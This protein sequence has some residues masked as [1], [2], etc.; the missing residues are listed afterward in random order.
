MVDPF[1]PTAGPNPLDPVEDAGGLPV[2]PVANPAVAQRTAQ[3]AALASLGASDQAAGIFAAMDEKTAS[4]RAQIDAMGDSEV[5]A[6]AAARMQSQK[7]DALGTVLRDALPSGDQELVRGSVAAYANL[8][9][10]DAQED[11]SY[12]L[13]QQAIERVQDLAAGGN[14]VQARV[15]L[16]N[17]ENGNALD[18]MRDFTAKQ[19]VMQNMIDKAEIAVKDQGWFRSLADMAMAVIPLNA[20][21][22]T[23]NV[24]VA[25]VTKRWYDSLLAGERFQS[26]ADSLW[27]L[28]LAEFSKYINEDFMRNLNENTT[29]FGYHNN[30][31]ELELLTGLG[32]RTPSV[33]ETNAWNTLDI[34]GFVP[35]TK[36]AG[37]GRAV[38]GFGGHMVANG[39]R[40]EAAEMFAAEALNVVRG[41]TQAVSGDGVAMAQIREALSVSAVTPNNQEVKVALGVSTGSAY[42]RG[43]A[44]LAALPELEARARLDGAELAKALDVTRLRLERAF[45]RE[46]KDVDIEDVELAGGSRTHRVSVTMGRKDGDGFATETQ[47]N[48]YLSSIG[49]T[50]EAIQDTSGQWFAKV[51]TDLSETGFTTRL[52]NVKSPSPA[53][54]LLNAR[55]VGD[56][57]LAN[58]AAVAG[59]ARNKLLRTLVEPYQDTFRS[60]AKHEKDSLAQVL[61]A[62]E[63]NATW[64]TK[65]QIDTLYQR[66]FKRSPS[67]KELKAYQAARDINDMEYS[68][69]NDE[70]YKQKVI[71]GF[72]SVSFDTGRGRVDAA[73]AIVDRELKEAPRQRVFDVTDG[74]HYE[75]GIPPKTW[76]KM[77]DQGYTIIRLEK[78]MTLAD[79]T[80]IKTFAVRGKDVAIE[81]LSREQ[82]SY[83]AGGHRMYKGKYFVKQTSR[84]VQPDTG[85]TFLKNPNTYIAAETKAEADF[86]SSRMEAARQAMLKGDD[87][88]VIDEILGGH[89]G[90]PD[91]EEFLRGFDGPNPKFEKDTPFGTYYDREMPEEYLNNG[92]ALE[93]VDEDDT[94]FNG[95]LRTNGRM[96]TGRKGEQ[97][98][99]YQGNLAPLIDPYETINRSLMNIASLTSF[100]DYKIQSVERW[101]ATFGKVIDKTGMADASPLKLLMEAPLVKGGNEA[102]ERA[103]QAAEAQ[104]SIIKRTLGWKTPNDLRSEAYG[105]RMSEFVTGKRVDG[106]IPDARKAVASWWEDTNPISALR[107]FAFDLKLGMFNVAQL[108]LQLSTATAAV[109]LSPKLGMQGWSMI[110]PMR[111]ML[112]GKTL[113]KEA[114]ETRL[115]TL[116]KNGVHSMGGFEDAKE[117][118]E[119]VRTATRS[120]F[121]DLGGTHGLM[122]HYGPSAAMDGFASGVERT[123][124]AGRFFFYEAERWNRIVAYRIAW[125]ETMKAGLRSGSPEFAAKLAGRAED[126][127][128]SMSRESQAWWQKGLLSIPTQFWAYN[129]RMIEAMLPRRL[130]GSDFGPAQKMRLIASQSLLYGSAG[131]P[132]IGLFTEAMKSDDPKRM[133]EGGSLDMTSGAIGGVLDRGLLDTAVYHMT[134]ADVSIGKRYGSGGWIVDTVRNIFGAS[135][136]GEMSTAEMLGG[137]TFNIMGKVG[138]DVLKPVM[139]YA[140]MESGDRSLPLNGDSLLRV[141]ANVSTVGNGLKAY[142]VFNYGTYSSGTGTTVVTGLPSSTAFAVALGIPPAEVDQ[143]SHLMSHFKENSTAVREAAKIINNYRTNMLNRPDQRETIQQDVNTFVRL[144]PDDVREKALQQAH[145]TVDPS[146][147]ESLVNR[148]E[149]EEMENGLTNQ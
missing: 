113:T 125:D 83:R 68:L 27:D 55:N 48:R 70:I 75:D 8:A 123:R 130:G 72:R 116:V 92:S 29:L 15:M 33:L 86:W 124:E 7:L 135:S 111:F 35:W 24:D 42:E 129:A 45:Q 64:F 138:T 16:T 126:Y 149:K 101:A 19:L 95:F 143:T 88:M 54:F 38:L 12:A 148:L 136:Y 110:A 144:L 100:G 66:Q 108:P 115:D 109:A 56:T 128:F 26:E 117:F 73:N 87:A 119:F 6:E 105:R 23:G 89:A 5:R 97:L 147:Y 112:G 52:L 141:A 10:L 43:R 40:R 31:E 80:T 22:H 96:Y 49:E 118:K 37:A 4:Y 58:D 146:L 53:R 2:S 20:A 90:L 44:L 91:A 78:P 81:N 32:K 76:A 71:K 28:P 34:A 133:L 142:M 77:Q 85:K 134:G 139:E 3:M 137:A 103:R 121:F 127:S 98:P 11:A 46:V 59:N 79:G 67:E 69:R 25:G 140:A 62:G 60:L 122:D 36:V 47:A 17:M 104:R 1:A 132:G 107:G 14:I 39:A 106:I 94:G 145:N 102:M 65:D 63:T 21:S 61:Q 120:G 57:L 30:T 84:G 114:F 51:T 99:D 9:Q 74:R 82:I 18:V 13:E 131:L 93:F 41:T 50:G